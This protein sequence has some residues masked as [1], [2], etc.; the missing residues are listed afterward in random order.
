MARM[1]P[2]VGNVPGAE[3]DLFVSKPITVMQKV[4]DNSRFKGLRVCPCHVEY[5]MPG[6]VLGYACEVAEWESKND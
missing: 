2:T 4:K 3:G 5:V 6:R 1:C